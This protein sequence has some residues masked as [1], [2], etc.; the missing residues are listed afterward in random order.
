MDGAR[1]S[2]EAPLTPGVFV[3]A[4]LDLYREQSRAAWAIVALIAIPTQA[5]VWIMIRVSLSSGAYARDGTVHTGS[6]ALPW[7]AIVLLGFLS[8]VLTVGAL[9]RLLVETYTGH[10]TTWQESLGYASSRLR[11]LLV[12][13]LVAGV[14]LAIGYTLFLVPGVFLT[15]S[16]CAAG[17]ALMFERVTPLRSLSRSA[18]LVRGHWWPTFGALVAALLI[19]LGVSYL[20]GILLAGVQ[21]SSSI[22]LVLGVQS[23]TRALGAIITYPFVAAL[24]VV[25]YANLR[26]IKEGVNPES[27]VRV[28]SRAL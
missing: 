6:A 25:I 16:W 23:L 28:G 4:A 21:S 3:R 20:V 27:L 8:F 15:V 2:R 17:P 18:E 10:T 24:S 12:M 14:A 11:P 1:F 13:A 5:L 19:W 9:S 22:D 26:A 7:V